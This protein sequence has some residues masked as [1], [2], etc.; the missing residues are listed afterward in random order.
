MSH[1]SGLLHQGWQQ[2]VLDSVTDGIYLVDHA[3]TITYWNPG[4][5]RLSGYPAAVVVGRSCFANILAH[6]DEGGNPLCATRCPLAATI[7]DGD[8]REA[9]VWLRHRDGH[10]LP[11]RIR[12][13]AIR[14]AADCVVGAVE[15]FTDATEL[16]TARADVVAAR[17]SAARD[18][19]TDL[20][21]RRAFDEALTARMEG[22]HRNGWGFSVAIADVDQL[23]TLN[24]RHG[25]PTG[26]L[27]LQTIA[28][29][30]RSAS[31]LGDMVCR[32][33]GDEFAVLIDGASLDL[34]V[35]AAER[36]RVMVA[37]SRI[38]FGRRRLRAT[39]SIGVAAPVSGESAE[40][41]LQRAD[42]ALYRAKTNGKNVVVADQR[43]TG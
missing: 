7:E 29:S 34:A 42:A 31:R 22:F 38:G 11:V 35:A 25:H 24:D 21:N 12:A 4:A 3:R 2:A 39:V 41:L 30:L 26:D 15:V 17:R 16:V 18:P 9:D 37:R 27:A 19:L 36:F 43:H 14:D 8:P 1:P 40:S 13:A 23:K 33:G 5:E 20:P 32:W 6:V 28:A 10:R